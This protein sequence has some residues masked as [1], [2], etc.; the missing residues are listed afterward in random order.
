[1]TR[2]AIFGLHPENTRQA[3]NFPI[4]QQFVETAFETQH[5]AAVTQRRDD[6]VRGAETEALPQFVSQ[7]LGAFD[8]K[9]LPV[10][11]GIKNFAAHAQRG[12]SHVLARARHRHHVSAAGGNLRDL[13]IRGALRHQDATAHAR[14][15]RIRRQR[16]AGIPGRILQHVFNA[17]TPEIADQHGHAAILEGTG[18]HHEFEFEANRRA[19]PLT[20]E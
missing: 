13:G 14:G 6:V 20:R 15:S 3:G 12:I 10:V 19:V 1:M 7:G 16:C 18:G 17:A 4:A 8:E 5:I 2:R 11:T 9:R